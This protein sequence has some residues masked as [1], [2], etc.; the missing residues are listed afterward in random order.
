MPGRTANCSVN[1]SLGESRDLRQ[2]QAMSSDAQL[3]D[4]ANAVAEEILRTIFGDDFTGC[5]VSLESIAAIVYDGLVGRA[6]A[7]RELLELYEK[8]HEALRLLA[9]PPVDGHALAPP[10]LQSLL[11][12]RLDAVR[13]LM[14]KIIATTATV[15][16]QRPEE[17]GGPA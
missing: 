9:T 10:E 4:L 2:G 12:D 1:F 15:K 11:G 5:H 6:A 16:G 13:H 14:D 8:A 3:H 17:A 7:D